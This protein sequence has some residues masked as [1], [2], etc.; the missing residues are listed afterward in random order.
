MKRGDKQA[1]VGGRVRCVEPFRPRGL[2]SQCLAG[3]DASKRAD[4]ASRVA[5]ARC[6]RGGRYQ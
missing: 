2:S 6:R 5:V 3:A 4:Q 1:D